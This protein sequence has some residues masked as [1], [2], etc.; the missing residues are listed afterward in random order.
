M[1]NLLNRFY[2]RKSDTFGIF[3]C[4]RSIVEKKEKI[5]RNE[6]PQFCHS[7]I[8]FWFSN[9]FSSIKSHE[10]S[11]NNY[12]IDLSPKDFNTE[13]DSVPSINT[14]IT[15]KMSRFWKSQHVHVQRSQL[16]DKWKRQL[17]AIKF[18]M[19]NYCKACWTIY[20]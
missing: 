4:N 19:L 2:A 5:V 7:L 1:I 12:S 3:Q 17:L 9:R 13:W 10:T 16:V 11:F 20:K 14:C 6:Y 18:A 15:E 8:E